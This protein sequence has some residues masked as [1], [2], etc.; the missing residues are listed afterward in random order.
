MATVIIRLISILQ[1]IPAMKP[2]AKAL[3]Q[4]LSAV[5]PVSASETIPL[6]HALGRILATAQISDLNVPPADNSAMDGYALHTDSLAQSNRLPVSQRVAAGQVPQPLQAGSAARIFTGAEVP[7]GANTVIMQE[8]CQLEEADGQ[9]WVTF[10][11]EVKAGNNVR[12]QGQDITKGSQVLPAGYRLN[13]QDLGLLAS[14]GI[15]RTDVLRPLRVAVLSTG[16]ELAEPGETA[17]PGQIYNSNRYQLAGLLQ[18]MGVEMIDLGRVED[19]FEATQQALRNASEQ[20]DCVITTGGVSVGEEDHVKPAVESL[21][22]LNLWKLA[23]KPGKPLAFGK[24]GDTPFFGLPGNPVSVFV[25]FL[26]FVRPYLYA[27]QGNPCHEDHPIQLPASFERKKKS[28][29]QEYVRV[30]VHPN[31]SMETHPNQSSGVLSSTSWANAL[32]IVEP[33]TTVSQGDMVPV[34]TFASMFL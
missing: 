12:R 21:G 17:G 24:I 29:R 23:L 34:I 33:D 22:E 16:D 4:I 3:D 1:G 26:L 28:I 15:G 6:Q 32:T 7:T 31:G 19:T 13:P 2:I 5:V 10:P 9:T 14:I 27:Q 25:T 8:Q 30:R 18:K 20:A 11:D